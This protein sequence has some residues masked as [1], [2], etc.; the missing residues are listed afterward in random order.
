MASEAIEREVERVWGDIE[1]RESMERAG[2]VEFAG[3]DLEGVPSGP[4]FLHVDRI[5]GI[6]W[7]G[8][9]KSDRPWSQLAVLGAEELVGVLGGSGEVLA[10]WLGGIEARRAAS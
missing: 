7:S 5:G 10:T 2:I 1:R 4:V 6:V 9:S 3:A 8:T